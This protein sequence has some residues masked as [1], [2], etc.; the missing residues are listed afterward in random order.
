[1]KEDEVE[2]RSATVSDGRDNVRVMLLYDV[3]FCFYCSS[4]SVRAERG[5]YE[6]Y[7]G[8]EGAIV[9]YFHLP[10]F[11][12]SSQIALFFDCVIA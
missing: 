12:S 2:A 8:R 11:L 10:C 6:E 5:G 1:M 9:W 7:Y 3:D 4:F